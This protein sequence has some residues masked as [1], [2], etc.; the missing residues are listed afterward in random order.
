MLWVLI[1]LRSKLL[2]LALALFLSTSP[3]LAAGK[4]AHARAVELVTL[5]ARHYEAGRFAE[6]IELLREAYTVEQDPTILY[7]LGRAYEGVG[8]LQSAIEAYESYIGEE[9]KARDRGAIEKRIGTLKRQIA[10]R[11]KLER[12]R[13]REARR[14]KAARLAAE[15]DRKRRDKSPP[16]TQTPSV[17][18]WIVAGLGAAVLG[19]GVVLGLRSN[20]RH[21]EAVDERTAAR[22]ED[23]N[24]SAKSLA[25][26]ANVCF[27][28]GGVLTAGGVT[29]AILDR[30]GERGERAMAP[31]LV[32]SGSF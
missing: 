17:L 15:R 23:L 12:E 8:D 22:S 7:N 20:A 26:A 24:Q 11:Q 19:G 27:V 3:L 25:V 14:A 5:S 30:S 16:R 18:P 1:L 21:R 32:V 10:E 4:K 29:W 31:Q 28:A 6:A 2:L 9:P 13:D